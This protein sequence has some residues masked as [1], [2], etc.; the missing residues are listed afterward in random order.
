MLKSVF[1]FTYQKTL[2]SLD[3][4]VDNNSKDES[5]NIATG[6][7]KV[8]WQ[9]HCHRPQSDK[10]IPIDHA[11]PN[12]TLPRKSNGWIQFQCDRIGGVVD[13]SFREIIGI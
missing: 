7:K 11:F 4:H 12:L 10:Q 5:Y 8:I 2:L 1:K 13:W 9:R 6:K 3:I